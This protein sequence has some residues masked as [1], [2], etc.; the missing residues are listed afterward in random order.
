MLRNKNYHNLA[1]NPNITVHDGEASF[2]SRNAV[3]V[4]LAD[5]DSLELTSEHIFINTGARSIIPAIDGV[6]DSKHVYTSTTIM[7]LEQLPKR[8]AVIGRR[9][10]RAG[11]RVHVRRVWFRGHHTGPIMPT[12]S[13][14]E[15]RDVAAAVKAVLEKKG[16]EFRMNAKNRIH[17]GC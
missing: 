9:L 7:Q 4:K 8:L 14:K 16:V 13:R 10:H 6:K 15:D 17:Q 3:T 5:N 11:I 12:S 1:D 2:I